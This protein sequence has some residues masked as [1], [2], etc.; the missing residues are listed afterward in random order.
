[1]T[2]ERELRISS[3]LLRLLR[4]LAALGVATLLVG[5]YVAPQRAWANL[6]L[7]SFLLVCTGL[8]G[9]VFI[10]TQ[11]VSGAGWSVAFRRV[12]EAMTAVLPVGAA[13]LAL[14]FVFR[15]S[16]YEWTH[17]AHLAGFKH[18]WLSYPFFLGRA[19]VY[20]ALWLLFTGLILRTS[21]AQDADGDLRH[22]HRNAT[23]SAGFLVVFGLTFWLASFDWIMS[24]EPEW[25]STIFG[26]YHF[27]G[28]FSAGL[29]TIIVLVI[30]LERMG[31]LHGILT[32]GHLHDL[33][34]LLFAFSTFWA[35]IWFSQYMLIWY[36]NIPEETVYYLRR[37]GGTWTPLF[38][39]NFV[40][41]WVVPFLALLSVKA[42]KSPGAMLKV[43]VLV[44]LGRWLDLYLMIMPT[45]TGGEPAIGAW[46]IG[47]AMGAVGVFA[48][49]FFRALGQAATVPVG[50]PRLTESLQEHA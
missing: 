9:I 8:A 24:L 49:V 5:M 34:K 22:T 16:L 47:A 41:N 11:Y 29:A 30:V 13:G 6:L 39:L 45:F 50:D 20:A 21:R 46:E 7:V 10:A 12:P 36:A 44:L 31:P 3:D 4:V 1:M 2:V 19:A 14:V 35:Y 23:L 28:L 18:L 25:Y 43:A 33:G 27:A 37:H 17:A 38:I 42:K 40:L 32:S 26:I 15:P 48:L